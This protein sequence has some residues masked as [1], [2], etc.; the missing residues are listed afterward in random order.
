MKKHMLIGSIALTLMGTAAH[1]DT[2]KSLTM[3]TLGVES[4]QYSENTGAGITASGKNMLNLTQ[5]SLGY[6][7]VSDDFG[8]YIT[9]I[10]TLTANQ[11]TESWAMG[12]YG[13]VQT[14]QRKVMLTDLHVQA[15]W[16]IQ[17]SVQLLAGLGMNRMS[18]SRSGFT[19]PKGTRGVATT[20]TANQV[21]GF[22]ND[23]NGPIQQLTTT[24]GY[25]ARQPG[26]IFEDSTSLMAE[27]GVNYDSF[28]QHTN[29][30]R[31]IG[32]ARAA[33]PVY[34]YVTNSNYPNVSWSNAFKGYNLHADLGLGYQLKD[35][36][37]LIMS[38]S[39]DYRYRPA[40]SVDAATGGFVP[41][42]T[43][44]IA[45]LTAGLAWSF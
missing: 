10:S 4:V 29:G 17:D 7:A 11:V 37:D 32:S 43:V 27:I 14:N 8:F 23:P 1:A 39:G 44:T 25:L 35:N 15:A 12:Q 31:F 19:Y 36:F 2:E 13:T 22:R 18:F 5:K 26:A 45:R 38:V 20:N 41:N 40:T 6:T 42:V 21:T 16:M 28:F 3:F 9:T 30:L 34:Y 24:G 33:I